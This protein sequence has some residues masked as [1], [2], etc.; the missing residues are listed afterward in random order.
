LAEE[1]IIKNLSASEVSY[2]VHEL[3]LQGLAINRDFDFYYHPAQ[4]PRWDDETNKFIPKHTR[5]VF[6]EG[7]WA[8]WFVLKY[9]Q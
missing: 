6:Y 3:K 9:G 5:F 7:K 1:V 8:T 4:Q 2:I